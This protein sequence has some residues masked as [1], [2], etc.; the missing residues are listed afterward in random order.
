MKRALLALS[1][2]IPAPA[3]AAAGDYAPQW[4]AAHNQERAQLRMQ[5]LRWSAKL[6]TEAQRWADTL[7]QRGAFEHASERGGAGENLWM[8]TS[9]RFGADQMIRSFLSE[10]R[11]FRP[12]QFPDVSSNG[13]WSAVG[14][15][16]QIIWPSTQEV[17][18]ALAQGQ[19]NDVLVCRYWP[20]GNVFG[21]RV[22]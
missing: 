7:A 6:A 13:N 14:H 17:G 22:G 1:L 5:P 20:A 2:L 12:G 15:Y 16:S 19:G 3:L 4:L 9:G 18:C 21:Q 10:K 11:W 8:G